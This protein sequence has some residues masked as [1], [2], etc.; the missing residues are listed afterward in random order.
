M[1]KAL[2]IQYC[3]LQNE[4][5]KLNERIDRL[6]RQSSIVSDVVQNGYKRHAVISGYDCKR[7][8]RLEKLENILKKRCDRLWDLKVEIEEWI[9][10]IDDSKTRM[11]FEHRYI[12]DMNWVQV[13]LAMRI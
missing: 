12:D 9:D 3:D 6:H 7:K 10:T 11:I 5:K 1:T 13:Q 8:Y 4:I 2:L